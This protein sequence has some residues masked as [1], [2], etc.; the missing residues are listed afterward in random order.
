MVHGVDPK[1]EEI[2]AMCCKQCHPRPVLCERLCKGDRIFHRGWRG[3]F[4]KSNRIEQ[5]TNW[6]K[7]AAPAGNC[8][9][10]NGNRGNI[11][12]HNEESTM[13]NQKTDTDDVGKRIV[14]LRFGIRK[15][16]A[17]RSGVKKN[18]QL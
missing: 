4:N 6:Q 2:A 17:N 5:K 7:E 13:K 14:D 1:L 8:Q 11:K 3:E 12:N 9:R 18:C 15:R 16:S 10:G